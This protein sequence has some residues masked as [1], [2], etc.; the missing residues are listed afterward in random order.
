MLFRGNNGRFLDRLRGRFDWVL[1]FVVLALALLGVTLIANATADPY[2]QSEGSGIASRL[3]GLLTRSAR[4]QMTWVGVGLAA[5]L[6]VYLLFDYRVYGE[7]AIP[8]YIAANLILI[9]VLF[10]PQ[11]RGISAFMTWMNDRTFQ[12][13]EVCKVAII[14]TL[15]RH[16]SSRNSRISTIK[17]FLPYLLHFALPFGII[18]LQQDFGSAL[19]FLAIFI[20]MVFVSGIDLRVFLGFAAAGGLA[21]LASWPFLSEFRRERVLNFLDPSRDISGGGMH[22]YYSKIAVG[23]GQVSGKGLFV[24]GSISQLDFV[25]VKHSDF[26]FAVT[27]ESVGFVGCLL[28]LALY[29][30]LLLRLFYLSFKMIDPFGSL[31]IAGVGSMLLFHIIEN[32]GMTIG[33]MPVTGIPLPFL[34]YGGSSLLANMLAMG[35]C[36]NVLRNQQRSLF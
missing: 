2:A 29:L 35:L 8:I 21:A 31:I 10:L 36:F 19:V 32:I 28:I 16:L 5:F 12:P 1:F 14:I 9:A 24:E 11:V 6:V 20:G 34:S 13:S 3:V 33:I 22:V 18:I 30:A 27:A 26:I 25:P 4:L 23:S 17:E 15:A 7:L